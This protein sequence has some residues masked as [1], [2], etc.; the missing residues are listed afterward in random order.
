MSEV[1][2]TLLRWN[3][4]GFAFAKRE[5]NGPDVYCHAYAHDLNWTTGYPLFSLAV[6]AAAL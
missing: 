4:R 5:D 2:G 1:V 3:A 6:H